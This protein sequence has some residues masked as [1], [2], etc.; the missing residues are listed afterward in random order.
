L[1]NQAVEALR[2]AGC[3]Q[4]WLY[5]EERNDAVGFYR[6]LGW[7]EEGEA[8]VRDWHGAELREPRFALSFN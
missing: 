2:T 3:E 5:T 4:A 1:L 8:R 6:S 7:R